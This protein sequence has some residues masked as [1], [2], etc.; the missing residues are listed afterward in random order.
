ME[1]LC[2]HGTAVLNMNF[3]LQKRTRI[4]ELESRDYLFCAKPIK[5]THYEYL[6]L[7]ESQWRDQS[8]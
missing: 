8:E 2:L 1:F 4:F 7:I 5:F 6:T 3:Y